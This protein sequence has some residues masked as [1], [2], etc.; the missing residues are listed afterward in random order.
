MCDLAESDHWDGILVRFYMPNTPNVS[1]SLSHTHTHTQNSLVFQWLRV[2]LPIQGTQVHFLL[3]EDSHAT[4]QLGPCKPKKLACLKPVLHKRRSHC[5]EKPAHG[6]KEPFI[7]FS[8]QF[9]TVVK[10]TSDSQV[11][12]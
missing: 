11:L 5:N 8:T 12:R 2:H 4:W 7:A 9:N 3:W 1:L 6:S 10:L